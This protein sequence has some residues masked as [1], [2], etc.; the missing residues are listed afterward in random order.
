MTSL[1]AYSERCANGVRAEDA[2]AEV[3]EREPC[4]RT[5]VHD[6]HREPANGHPVRAAVRRVVALPLER[7][8]LAQLVLDDGE[9]APEEACAV[10]EG[11]HLDVD[12]PAQRLLAGVRAGAALADAQRKLGC[13]CGIA[14]EVA[15]VGA[16]GPLKRAPAWRR[17]LEGD[18]GRRG[19]E[20]R[21]DE[22]GD[23][24]EGLGGVQEECGGRWWLQRCIGCIGRT[25]VAQW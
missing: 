17:A 9:P 10:R 14:D 16:V 13:A 18:R 22:T 2:P 15:N 7:L 21:K 5:P 20:L 12:R 19:G 23:V 11:R 3:P 1:R 8:H 4:D 24:G 25:E 6:E